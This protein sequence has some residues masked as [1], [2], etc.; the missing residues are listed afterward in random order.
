[1]KIFTTLLALAAL[2]FGPNL[3]RAQGPT[4]EASSRELYSL[5]EEQAMLAR[6]IQRLRQTMDVLA[7]RLE[8]EGRT[9]AVELLREGLAV[10]DKRGEETLAMTLDE[11][12]EAVREELGS[13]QWMQSLEHQEAIIADLEALLEVLL[14][15]QDLDKLEQRIE[16]LA[17]AKADLENLRGREAE[18]R[19]E[20]KQAAEKA[21]EQEL[22][23]WSGQLDQLAD[24]QSQALDQAERA[25]RE[26]GALERERIAKGLEELSARE[27]QIAKLLAAWSPEE[28]RASKNARAALSDAAQAARAAEQE[29]A[30]A[31]ALQVAAEA[32]A[33]DAPI[34]AVAKDLERALEGV[35]TEALEKAM[36]AL[37]Q[38]TASEG[39]E[40]AQA[41]L[42]AAADAAKARAE[43]A[44]AEA[45]AQA[46][47]AQAALGQPAPGSQ[48]AA[49]QDALD[50]A[51]ADSP[52]AAELE[53]A[54]A[55]LERAAE[56]AAFLPEAAA[57]AQAENERTT[58]DL[59]TALERLQEE[60][61]EGSSAQEAAALEKALNSLEK[62]MQAMAES[63]QSASEMGSDSPASEQA[64]S[65]AG[66]K[67]SA[68]K[69]SL[70]EAIAALAEAAKSSAAS[71]DSGA[72]SEAQK[73]L[74]KQA[75]QLGEQ[76]PASSPPSA[77]DAME[78]AA[79]AMQKAAEALEQGASGEATEAQREALDAL[80]EAAREAEAGAK[81][82]AQT[83][84]A[85]AEKQK[86]IEDDLLKLATR[87]EEEERQEA[88]DAVQS[89]ASEASDAS[90]S[91]QSGDMSGA[92][93]S[94][95]NV[96]EELDKAKA[97]L[98]AEEEKYQELRRE[99]ILIQLTEELTALL[100]SQ[101]AQIAEVQEV[102]AARGDRETP[103]RAQ[104]LRLRRVA[105]E[106]TALAEKAA[107][108]GA[109]LSEEG[110]SVFA[111]AMDEVR[112]DL[113]QA[114]KQLGSPG[115]AATGAGF[116]SGWRTQAVMDDAERLLTWL[117][118]ALT[119]EAERRRDDAQKP[120]P[121]G[122]EGEG[123]DP[124]QSENRL[125]PSQA[126][127][128]LLRSMELDVQRAIK[129]TSDAYPELATTAPED[130]DPLI[131]EDLMRLAG[132][133]NRVTEL[134]RE[135]AKK[136]GVPGFG[137]GQ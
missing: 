31:E 77:K 18:V 115:E 3:A 9:R 47:A 123:E 126:E 25:A 84:E 110:S 121:S 11:R 82:D 58:G 1:M 127:L 103:S 34:E 36:D 61:K 76:L 128:R 5:A 78:R 59:K 54:L 12:M 102:D 23:D 98:D 73:S 95:R 45:K 52:K 99:E 86:Q 51:L 44:A 80:D 94:E 67:A 60:T 75:E 135:V 49:A 114:A 101:R 87:L 132:R 68:A 136:L 134:F 107:E 2:S 40:E 63:A 15:R 117:F 66:Q 39:R 85:L 53:A 55:E 105:R 100:E 26:S 71:S 22:G 96:E 119:A 28:Q 33:D 113:E 111:S 17:A 14:D 106:E 64:Q 120:P 92:Q 70:D 21:I 72:Q 74:A 65:E 50:E 48:N 10:L 6:Q 91:L 93:E 8:A 56:N 37:A 137:G 130:I 133:H 69:A 57:G 4:D 38:G 125:V 89:A 29:Q 41:Q 97:E 46:E 27:A 42:Q 83:S 30:T 43:A 108:L 32:L 118:D 124:Q 24:K 122:G 131:L 20:T 88:A 104:K 90:E 112:I 79:E 7:G 16:E 109:L 13:G 116:D 62:A 129:Q 81:P 35:A 19:R